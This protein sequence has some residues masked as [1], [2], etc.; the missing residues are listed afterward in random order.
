MNTREELEKFSHKI[1]NARNVIVMTGA[2]IST[3]AGIPDF[4]SQSQG[5]YSKISSDVFSL[6]SFR[7]DPEPFY[8][9]FRDLVLNFS[10]AKPTIA[11][12]FSKYFCAI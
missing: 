4:R 9:V 1:C 2:G 11:H 10:N 8:K 7:D 5:L 3:N 12:Y 6:N